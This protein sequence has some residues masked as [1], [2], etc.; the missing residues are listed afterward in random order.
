MVETAVHPAEG[1]RIPVG[2][3]FGPYAAVLSSRIRSQRAYRLSFA[4]DMAGATM[5]GL[6]EFAEVWVVFHQAK[7]LGGLDLDAALLLFGLS[8]SA[9][10]L[11]QLVFGHLDKLPGLIRLGMLDIYH[12]RPQPVLLQL[13]TSDFSLRR[14]AR[15]AVAVVVLTVGLVR[16]DIDWSA[17]AVVLIASTVLSGI[18]LFG[19]LFVVAAGCQFFL[20]DGAEL[21]NSFTYGGSFAAT[22]PA[23]VFPTPLKLLFCIAIPVAFTAYLPT[24]ALLDL[25]GPP[26]MPPW[27]AWCAPLAAGWVWV[28][29]WVMWRIGTRH[30]QSGGG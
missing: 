25:P 20:I 14:L 13:V 29:A 2:S 3:R 1:R 6:V 22:Q 21:T 28:L 15:A 27:L 10:A 30:Y 5:V 9:F 12:L 19:G 4:S 26:G 16:N 23:S 18:V 24:L 7:V 8:N 17:A 11:A